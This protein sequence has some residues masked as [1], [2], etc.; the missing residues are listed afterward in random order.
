MRRNTILA[1]LVVFAAAAAHA[2]DRPRLL[3]L[4]PDGTGGEL[5]PPRQGAATNSSKT[6]LYY[7]SKADP[8]VMVG[9]ISLTK[10][11]G[12]EPRKASFAE[13][14][15]VTDG[16]ATIGGPNGQETYGKGS[17]VLLPRGSEYAWKKVENGL[18]GYFVIFDRPAAGAPATDAPGGPVARLDPNGPDGDGLKP[19]EDGLTKGHVYHE[20]PDGSTV[21]VWEIQPYTSP[22]FYDT[23]YAELMVFLKGNVTLTTDD[24]QVEH[25]KAGEVALVPKGI[26]YKW[27]SDN[28]RKFYVIFD[29]DAPAA[30]AQ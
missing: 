28:V 4:A 18:T 1:I 20:A 29:K 17:A 27:S 5:Q 24:G 21:G 12:G 14:F 11:G 25:F 19:S 2:Q 22:E 30:T 6:Y 8:R 3:R 7:R 23:E 15:Y 13:F 26:R 16:Q 9:T 10:V